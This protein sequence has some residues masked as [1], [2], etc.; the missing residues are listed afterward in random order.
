MIELLAD[1]ADGDIVR[2]AVVA[3]F[4]V[5]GDVIVKEVR[6]QVERHIGVVVAIETVLR[7]RQVVD[8]LAGADVAV[9]AQGTI[10]GIDAC[11]GKN[12][13]FKIYFV[14]AIHAI[15]G[16]GIGRYV[17]QEFTDADPVVVTG[18][19]ATIDT[20]VII[21]SRRKATRGMTILAILGGDGHMG[22]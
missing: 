16:S 11:M 21:G 18:G 13:S 8:G 17:I 12:R 7:R 15:L 20:G 14:M 22:I 9:V 1:G 5:A 4:T 6:C 19:A 3:G 10:A 2:I